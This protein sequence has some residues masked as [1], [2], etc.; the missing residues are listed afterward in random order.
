MESN[1]IADQTKREL[2]RIYENLNPAALY[3][4][5]TALQEQLEEASAGK[6]EGYGKPSYRCPDIRIGKRRNPVAATA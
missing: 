3:R 6:L 4:R 5:I 2:R 1:Q